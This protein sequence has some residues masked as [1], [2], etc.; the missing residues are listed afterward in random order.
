MIA[1]DTGILARA[2]NRWSP[3]HARASAVVETLVNGDAPWALPWP[4]VHEFLR[5]VTH[6]YAVARPLAASDALGFVRLLIGSPAV[7][8]LGAGPHHAAALAEVLALLPS[9]PGPVPRLELA[10]VLREHGVRELLSTDRAT[11]AWRFLSVRNPLRGATAWSPA[12]APLRRYRRVS[13]PRRPR[14]RS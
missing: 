12:A 9:V 13:V 7:R 6:P 5:L 3:D 1:V 11:L 8:A 14:D 10:A 4:A 2:I